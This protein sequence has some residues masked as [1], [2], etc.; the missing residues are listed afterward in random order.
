[1]E[2]NKSKPKEPPKV[3]GA[4]GKYTRE[5]FEKLELLDP[6][7]AIPAAAGPESELTGNGVEGFVFDLASRC[8]ACDQKLSFKV[9]FSVRQQRSIIQVQVTS[10]PVRSGMK[11]MQ[12]I[13]DAAG[14]IAEIIS[15]E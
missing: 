11:H 3:G 13:R 7:E 8:P 4:R 12:V 2:Q 6:N 9:P 15:K 10:R 1:M 5:E 14:E